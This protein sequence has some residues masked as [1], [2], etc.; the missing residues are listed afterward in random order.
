MAYKAGLAAETGGAMVNTGGGLDEM[1]YCGY[2]KTAKTTA[3]VLLATNGQL[4]LFY[5]CTTT[6]N[7]VTRLLSVV[8]SLFYLPASRGCSV[9]H[10]GLREG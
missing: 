9:D 10:F 8:A 3:L 2:E 6:K 4:A 7:D 1:E 5:G